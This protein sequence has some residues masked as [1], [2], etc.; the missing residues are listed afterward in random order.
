M[1]NPTMNSQD[2]EDTAGIPGNLDARVVNGGQ[3]LLPG[4]KDLQRIR[5]LP[6]NGADSFASDDGWILTNL[7]PAALADGNGC[8]VVVE[9]WA[10]YDGPCHGGE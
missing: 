9:E 1:V 2:M 10:T 8:P 7:V 5:A 3:V 6:M 4:V